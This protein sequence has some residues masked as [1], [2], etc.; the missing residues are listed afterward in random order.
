MIELKSL[1]KSFDDK[2]VLI[3]INARFENGKTNLIIGQSG[4]GK[5]V[6]MKSIVGLLT[7]EKGEVLY[8]GT[9]KKLKDNYDY[10]RKITI[11][12]DDKLTLEKDYIVEEHK[13][14]DTIE[15]VIDIRKIE[16]S[17]FIKLISSKISIIDIDI[18]S[19]NIDDLI[20][21]LYEEYKI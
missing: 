15:Y 16:I 18:D 12:T 17:D 19:G 8:D 9:L 13:T 11:K 21:R 20:V 3:D 6:L 14:K 5:T 10:L 7:P 1:Y 2:D 4:S